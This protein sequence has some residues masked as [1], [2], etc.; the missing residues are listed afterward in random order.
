MNEA[1]ALLRRWS[2]APKAVARLVLISHAGSGASAYRSMAGALEPV[3]E[4]HSVQLPGREDRFGETPAATLSGVAEALAQ[5]IARTIAPPY[6]LFGHS[7]GGII[8]FEATCQLIDSGASPP[9]RLFLSGCRPPHLPRRTAPIS[10]LPDAEF[11]AAV[12]RLY[13]D[14]PAALLNAPDFLQL[15][16]NLLRADLRMLDAHGHAAPRALPIPITL[17]AGEADSAVTREELAGWAKYSNTEVVT[18][19]FPGG[20][21]YLNDRRVGLAAELV[22]RV[23]ADRVQA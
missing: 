2:A 3:V 12:Q 10:A 6:F 15:Y 9:L 13:G 18:R 22:E 11:V 14:L 4:C 8:A 17:F 23:L 7:M 19:L 20:H 5:E 16:T 1:R 21:F